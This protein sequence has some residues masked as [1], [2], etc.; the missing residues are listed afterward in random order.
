MRSREAE[1]ENLARE[2]REDKKRLK[3]IKRGEIQSALDEEMRKEREE[4]RRLRIEELKSAQVVCL[5]IFLSSNIAFML[6]FQPVPVAHF[7]GG[8]HE[9]MQA[10]APQNP[11]RKV[12]WL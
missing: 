7:V 2:C 8:I 3:E 10:R 1:E 12:V 5:K 9:K 6:L 11:V 4:M